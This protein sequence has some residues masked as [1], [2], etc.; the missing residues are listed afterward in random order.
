[1]HREATKAFCGFSGPGTQTNV[2]TGN[3]GCGVFKGDK[4]LKS[5][6]Q[7]LGCSRAGRTM[8]HVRRFSV[9][10]RPLRSGETRLADAGR[11][12]QVALS[13]LD[14]ACSIVNRLGRDWD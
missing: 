12:A 1:M 11:P 8:T 4:Y 6:L 5:M 10:F 14:A 13:G 2:A 3:W 9:N 7:W